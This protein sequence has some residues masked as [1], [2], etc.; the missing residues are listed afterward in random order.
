MISSPVRC[1]LDAS[2]GIKTV[3]LESDSASAT[4][5]LDHSN[6]DP[7]AEIHVPELFDLECRNILWKLVYR[8]LLPEADAKPKV[9]QLDRLK[10]VRTPNASL[11]DDALTIALAQQAS[12]YDAVYVALASRLGLPLVTADDKL[13]KKFAGTSYSVVLFASVTVPPPPPPPP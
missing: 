1:V 6:L 7:A 2:V 12:V 3:I 11:L 9:T 13:V 4:A 10:L 5:L 8:G